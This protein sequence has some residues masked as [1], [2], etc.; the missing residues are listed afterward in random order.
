MY[1]YDREQ[2]RVGV[3]ERKEEKK[4][5][6]TISTADDKNSFVVQIIRLLIMSLLL[7]SISLFVIISSKVVR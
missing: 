5:T 6:K 4:W 3:K 2:W 1:F 7:F